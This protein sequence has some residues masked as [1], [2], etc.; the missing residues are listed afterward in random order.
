VDA[1]DRKAS[2]AA[3]PDV[4]QL[5]RRRIRI[6]RMRVVM[7]SE[8]PVGRLED[9]T[10]FYAPLGEILC[11]GD[12]LVCCHLC[13][14]WLQTIGGTHLRVVHG[15]TL[16]EYR[17]AFQLLQSVPTC[18]RDVSSG[19][20]GRAYARVGQKGFGTPPSDAHGNTR[21]VPGW[22][23]LQ[24]V[25][26]ILAAELDQSRNGE[27]DPAAVAAGSHRKAWWRCHVAETNGRRRSITAW[28][29]GLAARGAH[30]FDKSRTAAPSSGSD[31]WPSDAPSSSPSFTPT[32]TLVLTPTR[33]R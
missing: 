8:A 2:I 22:R 16:A 19:L 6:A 23:S 10:V 7:T 15:W 11:A 21:P 1:D 28:A 17:E 25:R 20:R 27:L 29:V 13:G 33:S 26:P 9:G 24:R 5:Q 18:S 14:R 4:V 30:G 3:N 31:R 32:E 12:E